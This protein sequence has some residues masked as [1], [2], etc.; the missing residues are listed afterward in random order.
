[1]QYLKDDW[2]SASFRDELQSHLRL[3]MGSHR[4]R[5]FC[6]YRSVSV[7]WSRHG[8]D[9]GQLSTNFCVPTEVRT[10]F[11]RTG[12][13]ISGPTRAAMGDQTI[14]PTSMIASGKDFGG[15]PRKAGSHGH[16]RLARLAAQYAARLGAS[17]IDCR[18]R[19][20]LLLH[21]QLVPRRPMCMRLA[22]RSTPPSPFWLSESLRTC[23]SCPMRTATVTRVR[24]QP[25]KSLARRPTRALLLRT[26][27]CGR[28]TGRDFRS[29]CCADGSRPTSRPTLRATST[30]P[31]IW[32]KVLASRYAGRR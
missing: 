13:Y 7:A 19:I 21:L 24:P 15:R 29:T 17:E 10:T 20:R 8:D 6:R 9:R 26:L 25:P 16:Q 18:E 5:R 4:N 3:R 27:R 14:P 23:C 28:E 31:P 11:L 32:P 30:F 2:L 12:P 22:L 1:M